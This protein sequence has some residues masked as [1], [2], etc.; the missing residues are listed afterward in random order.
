MLVHLCDEKA[1]WASR[2][3]KTRL[4]FQIIKKNENEK[5]KLENKERRKIKNEKLKRHEKRKTINDEQKR[6]KTEKRK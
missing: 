6:L 3:P 1:C 4:K 5:W 2:K